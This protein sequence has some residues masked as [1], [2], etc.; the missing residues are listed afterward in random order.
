MAEAIPAPR[1]TEPEVVPCIFCE[2]LELEVRDD[3]VRIVAWIDLEKTGDGE[4]ERRI[5]ARAVMPNIVA[6]ALIRDLRKVLSRG[7]N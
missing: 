4:P 2:G 1:M 5:V 7:A 6:Q 3:V